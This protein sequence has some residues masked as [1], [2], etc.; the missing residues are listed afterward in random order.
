VP[1]EHFV[2]D[3]RAGNLPTVSWLYAGE[4]TQLYGDLSEHPPANITPGME[5]TMQQIQAVVDGG[6]W[7]KTA[8]FITWDDWG[9]WYDHVTP[10]QIETWQDG[11]QFRYGPRVP[12]LVVSPYAKR[13]YISHTLH[14]HVSLLAF[15]E[16]NFGLPAITKR[17]KEASDMSDCFDFTQTPLQPPQVGATPSA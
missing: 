15:C 2:K 7:G 4:S 11:T 16:K 5:W 13:A 1:S 12:C 17:D 10:P 3:A 8:I 9:G 14:S 6:L